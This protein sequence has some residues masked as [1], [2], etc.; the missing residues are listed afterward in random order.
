VTRTGLDTL[1]DAGFAALA[2]KR[3]GLVCHAPSVDRHLAH[4]ADLLR[5][6]KGVQLA[7]L[8]GPEHG[9][10]GEAQ[11]MIPVGDQKDPRTGVPVVSLYGA[12]AES[13]APRTEMLSGLDVLV[14]DL[15]D[16]GSRYYTYAATMGLVMAAAGRARVPVTVL[17]RPNP[18]GG[19]AVEGGVVEPGFES[20][21][22]LYPL[23]VRHGLTL[24]EI[25]RY[26]VARCG[27][28][29]DLEVVPMDGWRRAQGFAATGLPWVL[30]SPNMPTVDTALVYPGLCLIEGTN[31]SEGRGT[32]RPFETVGAPYLDPYALAAALESEHLPGVA[33]RPLSF[34]PTFQKWAGTPCHGVQLHVT[35]APSFA[36]LR[37]GYAVVAHA[38][39]LGGAA[40]AWRAEA[41]E[42]VKE[43]PAFDLLAGSRRP[44][45]FIENGAPVDDIVADWQDAEARFRDDREVALLYT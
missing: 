40:F 6:A 33:F 17:D 28:R 37:T 16:V 4:A 25:A 14:V 20:F 13:L 10:R 19:V 38:R 24:G 15:Q 45:A 39:R 12:S 18:I 21:V 34:L 9:I 1:R 22:G 43:I 32:T 3:V 36:P 5:A 29:C 7:R 27:V 35:D 41:Y 31:L 44:R 42:F 23:A 2:G 26:L 30:P 8:F 11:D